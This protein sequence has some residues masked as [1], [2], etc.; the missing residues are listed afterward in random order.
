MAEIFIAR[1][2]R[3]HKRAGWVVIKR[4]LPHL[5]EE[6][7]FVR[8]FA[9]EAHLAQRVQH[10]NV[11]RILHVGHQGGQAYI[12][13]EYIRGL[14]LGTVLRSACADRQPLPVDVAVEIACQA[15]AGLHAAHELR[16]EHGTLMDLVHR[17]VSPDNLLISDDGTVKL[18]DFGIAKASRSDVATT[19]HS[20][21]GK[22]PYMSPEQ[23]EGRPLDRRTDLFSLSVVLFEMLTAQR[24]FERATELLTLRAIAEEPLPALESVAPHLSPSL[25]EVLYRALARRPEERF[26]DAGGLSNALREAVPS[27]RTSGLLLGQ[28]SGPWARL[29]SEQD[30]A[31]EESLADVPRTVKGKLQSQQLRPQS[32]RLRLIQL[33]SLSLILSAGA[34]YYLRAAERGASSV[35]ADKPPALPALNFGLPPSFS[36]KTIDREMAP[37]A[38]YLGKQLGRP[39]EIVVPPTYADLRR[40]LLDGS[41]DFADL[42]PLQLILARAAA[43]EMAILAESTYEGARN[44]QG[45]IVARSDV[46]IDEI[47]A[48]GRGVFCF[49]DKGS[50]SG[51]L[52]PRRFLRSKGFDP[53]RLLKRVHFSGTHPQVMRDVIDGKCDAG[54]V[55]SGTLFFARRLGLPAHRLQVKWIT[56]EVP[57]DGIAAS[58][59]VDPATVERIRA[60]L[61]ALDPKRIFGR[62]TFG[63][64][65]YAISGFVEPRK[66][67]YRLVRQMAIDEGLLKPE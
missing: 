64:D 12:V 4:I 59:R 57:F 36:R 44:Y 10:P 8:M 66:G 48:L 34:W 67:T 43:P 33:V 11:V 58:P 41:I 27:S 32:W 54:A 65:A 45:Y 21:K 16:D 63:T 15:C 51:Y 60:A 56:G 38:Q 55:Y 22:F 19:A 40:Q 20:L 47:A 61:L 37:L 28:I 31:T 49:V 30:A 35:A 42:P 39:V 1:P 29:I 14:N 3:R 26:A 53:A 62:K 17:D 24:L 50:T 46:E 18:L 25:R 13:M 2:L 7:S 23:C 5:A 52:L 9:Q 6:E